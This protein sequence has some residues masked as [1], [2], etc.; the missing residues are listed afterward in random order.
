MTIL[1]KILNKIEEEKADTTGH[2]ADKLQDEAVEALLGGIGSDAWKTYM[3]NFADSPE[4]LARL[5]AEDPADPATNDPYV[6]KALA[7]LVS[8]AICGLETV[9]RLK[10][11]LEDG[12]LDRG[13]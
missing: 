12:L 6:R 1:E 11:R 10:S 9:T 3:Q 4:Q 13:L 2:V 5:T 8:N 7:Y